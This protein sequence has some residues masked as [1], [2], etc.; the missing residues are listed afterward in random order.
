M[1]GAGG[2]SEYVY[3]F[4]VLQKAKAEEGTGRVGHATPVKHSLA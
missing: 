1:S 4:V 3:T 2:P